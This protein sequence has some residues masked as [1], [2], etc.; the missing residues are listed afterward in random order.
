MKLSILT[1]ILTS[2]F[3]WAYAGEQLKMDPIDLEG[4]QDK[5]YEILEKDTNEFKHRN[6]FE[7]KKVKL[8]KKR[9]KMLLEYLPKRA[10][11]LKEYKRF[12]KLDNMANEYLGCIQDAEDITDCDELK[13]G[14]KLRDKSTSHNQI[15]NGEVKISEE[16]R[17]KLGRLKAVTQE[18][19]PNFKAIVN[20]KIYFDEQGIARMVSLQDVAMTKDLDKFK[21]ALTFY[22]NK[23]PI[24]GNPNEVA[25]QK[26]NF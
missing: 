25:Y 22:L 7:K 17:Y 10:K 4:Y 8:A 23:Y 15:E 3:S 5:E 11:N 14:L 16:L 9:T 18:F 6:K 1:F 12:E 24:Y 13:E 2:T 20:T 26:F 21:S 19:F